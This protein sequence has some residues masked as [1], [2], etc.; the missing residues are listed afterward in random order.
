[1]QPHFERTSL[2]FHLS[3]FTL[4][5][6]PFFCSFPDLKMPSVKWQHVRSH[7]FIAA[8]CVIVSTLRSVAAVGTKIIKP[9][10]PLSLRTA[11]IRAWYGTTFCADSNIWYSEP[12]GHNIHEFATS[13]SDSAYIIPTTNDKG[14]FEEIENAD[15]VYIYAHGGG[16]FIGHPLQYLD[17]YKRWVKRAEELG[18]KMVIIAPH[19]RESLNAL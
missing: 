3:S 2:H 14:V 18:K 8:Q 17:E 11:L 19:Y 15:V 12:A 16:L 6:S 9:S 4:F 10:Y 5:G 13:P 7:P 1:M